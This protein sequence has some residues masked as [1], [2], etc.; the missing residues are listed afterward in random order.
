[1]IV[2]LIVIFVGFLNHFR[3]MYFDREPEAIVEL[4]PLS[5]WCVAPMW[6]ALAPLLL[7]GV[8]WPPAMWEHFTAIGRVLKI[9]LP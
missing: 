3:E 2:L 8:W 9:G 6:F 5:R 1:M 4:L 7:F